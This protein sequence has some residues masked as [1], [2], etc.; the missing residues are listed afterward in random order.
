V[1]DA[2]EDPDDPSVYE[3]LRCGTLVT[4][5]THPGDCEECGGTL[6]NRAMSLE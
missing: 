5:Q 6:Q 2:V 1:F 4:A 3:C